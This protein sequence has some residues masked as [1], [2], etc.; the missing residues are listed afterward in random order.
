MRDGLLIF[1]SAEE[2]I[3]ALASVPDHKLETL[4][5]R[6]G[7]LFLQFTKFSLFL[8]ELPLR[9]RKAGTYLLAKHASEVIWTLHEHL[10]KQCPKGK[11]AGQQYP[12]NLFDQD[13]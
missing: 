9:E 2:L 13:F 1:P 6:T 5:H 3:R 10:L 4:N 8:A 7:V 11:H 12:V